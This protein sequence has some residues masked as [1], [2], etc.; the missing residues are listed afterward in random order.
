MT[1]ISER[2]VR[3]EELVDAVSDDSHG[4]QAFFLGVV[5]DEHDG[6]AVSAVTYEAF[7]P[8]AEK[9]LADIVGEAQTKW[10]ARVAAAHRLGKLEV[11]QASVGIAAGAPH[12]AEA[13]EACRYVIEEIK[14]RLPVFK[15]EHY[16]GGESRWLE[17]C[18][19]AAPKP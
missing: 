16:A 17:G 13:F 15:K 5:R 4:A 2:P 6:R 10:S 11:G 9:I 19:L 7:A 18:A 8:L 1:V 12:R 3:P 14:S